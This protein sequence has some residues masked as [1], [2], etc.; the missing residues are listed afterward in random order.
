MNLIKKTRN[1]LGLTQTDLAE[2]T[3]LSLRTIQRIEIAD[4]APKGHTLKVLSQVFN[5]EP[6]ILQQSFT[7]HNHLSQSDKDKL[8][9]IN[10]SALA[11]FVIPFGNIIVPLAMWRKTK[12][13]EKID[14]ACKR[15]INFQILWS[16]TL[17]FS[18]C[19]A[20][21]INPFPSFPLIL[22][23]LFTAL[24]INLIVILTTANSI[25]NN[26]MN[27]LNLPIRLL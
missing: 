2:K 10:L 8:K 23:V 7:T 13:S 24:V 19:I 15:I 16:I 1:Q 3:G 12:E 17:C 4:K 22:I 26:K 5:I 6:S 21:F 9:F 18:L 11:C 25:H 20:P 27:F 14:E